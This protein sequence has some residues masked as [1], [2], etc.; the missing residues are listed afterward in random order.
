MAQSL[1]VNGGCVVSPLGRRRV[2]VVGSGI[3]GLVCARELR[4]HGFEPAVF[5][6]ENR[7]GGRCSSRM[8]SAGLFDDGAQSLSGATGLAAYAPQRGG[9]LASVHAW[10]VPIAPVEDVDGDDAPQRLRVIGMVGVPSMRALADA[11]AQPLDVRLGI[12][13]RQ[14][15]RRGK[16][17]ILHDGQK[18][19]DE[20]FEAV[21]LAIPAPRA[22]PLLERSPALSSALSTV[23]YRSRW[24]LMMGTDRPARLPGYREFDGGPIERIAAIHSKPGRNTGRVQR[25][26]V[27]ADSHWS[28]QHSHDD[29]ETVAELMLANFSEHAG[30]SITPMC[31]AA[32]FWR[33]GVVATPAV[34]PRGSLCLWDRECQIGVCGDSVVASRLELVHRSGFDLARAIADNMLQSSRRIAVPWRGIVARNGSVTAIQQAEAA[35][36]CESE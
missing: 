29:P 11:I 22:L 4:R 28:A 35:A 7:R 17:W 2:A 21:V 31:L 3:G 32:H 34:T 18:E 19:I 24:V 15:Y 23:V 14:L 9:Q 12:P 27:E 1:N 33:H 36:H 30:R 6:A 25:W 5:E 20:G 10:S 16:L 26:F 8:T 13:I